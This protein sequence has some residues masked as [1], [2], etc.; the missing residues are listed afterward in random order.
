VI[1]IALANVVT[2][3]LPTENNCKVETAINNTCSNDN[4]TIRYDSSV[5]VDNKP[6]YAE[7]YV[8][9]NHVLPV[10][11]KTSRWPLTG[12]HIDG[13]SGA[14]K[15]LFTCDENNSNN[16]VFGISAYSDAIQTTGFQNAIDA[17]EEFGET[18]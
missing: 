1:P 7:Y 3:N 10:D 17:F 9:Y 2:L 11:G 16:C 12:V 4:Y 13:L 8:T 14:N 5:D 18:Y 6:T 15:D